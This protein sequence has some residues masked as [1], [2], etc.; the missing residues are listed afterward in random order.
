MAEHP[1]YLP[2]YRHAGGQ[3]LRHGLRTSAGLWNRPVLLNLVSDLLI[4]GVL[5]GLV[6]ATV[7]WV[8]ARS[9]FDV[10]EVR[11]LTPSANVSVA[12]LEYVARASI[13]GN[14]FT[15][16]LEQVRESLEKLPWVDRAEVRRQWPDTLEVRL[17]EHRAVAYWAAPD[18]DEMHLVNHRGEIF[19]ASS[20]QN[21]PV[22]SG[23][24]GTAPLLIARHREYSELLAPLGR[25]PKSVSLSARHAWEVRLD[26][27]MVL[28]LG[29]ESGGVPVSER[30]ERFVRT[31]PQAS[32]QLN[33]QAVVLADLRYRTGYALRPITAAQ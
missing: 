15:V 19:V 29:R 10:R 32:E 26:D 21:M 23:P 20:S 24:A 1:R 2:D 22:F 16:D 6:H 4:L 9:Y 30:L 33:K 27:G 3:T 18:S 12:Q 31:W 28:L 8:M 7:L 11:L 14:F 17:R 25:E 5:I 13:T